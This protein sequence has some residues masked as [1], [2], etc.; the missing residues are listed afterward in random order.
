ME[1]R[2]PVSVGLGGDGDEVA[3]IDEVEMTFGVTLDYADAPEWHTA[4]DV[5]A[6]LLRQLPRAVA[7]DPET[8]RRF[9]V[10][11]TDSTG[12]DAAAITP[13]SPL[14]DQTQPWQGLGRMSAM[15][16]VLLIAALVL[17]TTVALF[18]R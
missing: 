10:A 11:I 6:S 15:L 13:D 7:D 4:G 8:W 3:A 1:Q 2:P 17:V 5:F 14:I 16:W 18:A 12:V 9:A